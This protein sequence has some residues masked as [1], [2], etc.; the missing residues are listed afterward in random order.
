VLLQVAMPI[1]LQR[2]AIPGTGQ[3]RRPQRRTAA[4]PDFQGEG[5]PDR[6]A[7]LEQLDQPHQR[8]AANVGAA[9]I[10]NC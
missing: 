2:R 4:A 5:F 9:F 6:V 3:D 8:L 10:S 7:V 1:Y